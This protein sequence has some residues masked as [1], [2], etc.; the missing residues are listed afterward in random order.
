MLNQFLMLLNK[1]ILSVMPPTSPQRSRHDELEARITNLE[2]SIKETQAHLLLIQMHLRKC[3]DHQVST[4]TDLTNIAEYVDTI[5]QALN[6][7]K[8]LSALPKIK[9]PPDDDFWN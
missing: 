1:L 3:I 6:K 7:N 9:M 4:S 2:N 8:E 5:L